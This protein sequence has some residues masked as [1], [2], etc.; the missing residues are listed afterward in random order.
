MGTSKGGVSMEYGDDALPLQGEGH[1]LYTNSMKQGWSAP[2]MQDHY[3]PW[4]GSEVWGV[5]GD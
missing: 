4:A 1:T 5:N 3:A 2:Q